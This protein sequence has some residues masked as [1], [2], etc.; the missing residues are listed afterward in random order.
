MTD[1][2]ESKLR[3]WALKRNGDPIDNHDVVELL[4]AMDEDNSARH[5]ESIALLVAHCDEAVIRDKRISD[6]EAWRTTS[7]TA[8]PALIA[9]T[10]H[11]MIE[12]LDAD[13][14]AF[15][16]AHLLS[17][18]EHAARRETDSDGEDW[19]GRRDEGDTVIVKSRRFTPEQIV[20]SVVIFLAI[21][22]TQTAVTYF[23]VLYLDRR[24]R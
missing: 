12:Q 18:H 21:M 11:P 15:H 6:L 22:L 23:I 19:T 10:V 9:D 4:F 20:A 1:H 3:E 8:C 5:Q 7:V 16:N 17:D 13:H 2:A 14:L 24:Y